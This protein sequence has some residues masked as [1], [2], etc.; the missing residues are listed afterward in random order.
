[1]VRRGFSLVVATLSLVVAGC[2]QHTITST[3]KPQAPAGQAS[4]PATGTLVG[5]RA[6]IFVPSHLIVIVGHKVQWEN[7]DPIGR[8]LEATAGARFRSAVLQ[9]GQVFSWTPH[10]AGKI[11]YRD[12][13]HP[14]TVGTIVVIT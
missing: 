12:L 11:H 5:I 6:G 3:V 7:F 10:H 13:L 1:V 14:H 4:Q 8:Q 2:G 9:P